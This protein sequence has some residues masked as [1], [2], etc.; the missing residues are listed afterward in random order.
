M[1]HMTYWHSP[2]KWRNIYLM[3]ENHQYSQPQ[4]LVLSMFH[5]SFS[6]TPT[7]C[8]W[9]YI[10]FYPMISHC[11]PLYPTIFLQTNKK[12]ILPSIP[13]TFFSPFYPL[14]IPIEWLIF[15]HP[16]PPLTSWLQHSHPLD[17][18]LPSP[19]G[20]E[21][22][23]SKNISQLIQNG[24]FYHQKW[25]AWHDSTIKKWIHS[26]YMPISDENNLVEG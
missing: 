22:G 7:S 6:D 1:K 19:R 18:S 14:Y 5:P 21:S 11:I 15:L 24:W 26:Q 4:R 23:P 10:P 16:T 13:M 12:N 8:S 20:S 2:K 3:G 9:F 25:E 17:C